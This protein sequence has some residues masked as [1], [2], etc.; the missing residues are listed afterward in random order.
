MTKFQYSLFS[1]E[2]S[3]ASQNLRTFIEKQRSINLCQNLARSTQKEQ[4][5]F[6]LTPGLEHLALKHERWVVVSCGWT[7]MGWWS[8]VSGRL[9]TTLHTG[10]NRYYRVSQSN[11]ISITLE[12]VNQI[13]SKM[14]NIRKFNP[15]QNKTKQTWE[16]IH[17]TNIFLGHSSESMLCY[18]FSIEA[19]IKLLFCK[20]LRVFVKSFF[21]EIYENLQE[22]NS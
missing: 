13:L 20:Y 16:K 10:F 2:V 22:E 6:S 9:Y 3:W 5:P 14:Y 19:R 4:F 1:R 18:A 17:S 8:P 15:G 7:V 21:A 11:S 12:K